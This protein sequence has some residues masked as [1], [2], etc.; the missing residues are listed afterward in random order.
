MV[1]NS[2]VAERHVPSEE[3]FSFLELVIPLS[4]TVVDNKCI[5]PALALL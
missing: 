5:K 1:G 4:K 3:G 2:S